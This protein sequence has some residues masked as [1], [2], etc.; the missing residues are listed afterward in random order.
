ML[1]RTSSALV[2]AV[3]VASLSGCAAGGSTNAPRGAPAVVAAF[4]PLVFAAEGVG[5]TFVHVDNLTA[6]GVEPHDLELSADQVRAL[7][8]A[9][10]VIYLGGGFQPALE[11][12][13]SGLDATR[14]LDVL[15]G[16]E[17][18]GDDDPHV[19]L[20]PTIMAGIVQRVA[21]RLTDIDPHHTTTYERNGS[22]LAREL[23]GLDELFAAR[24]ARCATR[25]IVTSHA[26]FG[27]MAERYDLEQ[28]SISG[29]D[30]EAEPSPGRLAEVAR[31]VRDHD[32]ET[33][34]FEELVSPDVAETIAE[35]AG[36]ETAMLS[37]LESA[38]ASG[39]YSD[40]MK[41]NLAALIEALGCE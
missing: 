4:Y 15:E 40:A 14:K 12:F 39:D 31:F 22:Q 35:E 29:I 2:A 21:A 37:P 20:D 11:D 24:L 26:A 36:A 10:L 9:D 16:L 34:F 19:W 7:S 28:I 41:A 1:L 38:P 32:V 23:A 18:T 27:Y 30:P 25:D 6:P 33:I 17:L 8:N 5:G 13:V 3:A